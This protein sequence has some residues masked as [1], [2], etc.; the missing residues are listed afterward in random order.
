[1]SLVDTQPP[2]NV[3]NFNMSAHRQMPPGLQTYPAGAQN[4][5]PMFAPTPPSTNS[6][7]TDQ[8]KP[9]PYSPNKAYRQQP[10]Y[11]PAALRPTEFT[12]RPT[13]IPNRPRAPDTP[14]ASKD[15]S[16]D[17]LKSGPSA[18]G[19]TSPLSSRL[20]QEQNELMRGFNQ[21]FSEGLEANLEEVTG[22]P[23]TA[24]WKPDAA[25]TACTTCSTSFTWFFRRHHCRHCGNIFCDDHSK[26][27]VP[28]DQSARYHPDGHMSR[29]CNRCSMQWREIKKL[30][31]SRTSSLANSLTLSQ[32]QATHAAGVEIPKMKHP[33]IEDQAAH[34]MARSEGAMVWS[35]F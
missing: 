23:T 4:N 21:A 9:S 2:T 13:N 7:P 33:M 30:R 10:A 27:L 31:H 29:A 22:P 20:A 24:H 17:S 34:S 28:L 18:I 6:S 15:N 19:S 16:F 35:T 14:P 1:M 8:F 11:L 3:P 32:E 5:N 26:Q 25:V 12:S